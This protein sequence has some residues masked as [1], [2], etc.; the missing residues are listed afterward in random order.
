MPF[1]KEVF[2][3]SST[4]TATVSTKKWMLIHPQQVVIGV[5]LLLFWVGIS[6]TLEEF[7]YD[8]VIHIFGFST[9]TLAML[10][11][12]SFLIQALGVGL[13]AGGRRIGYVVTFAVGVYEVVASAIRHLYEILAVWPYREGVIS[14]VLAAGEIVV[15]ALLVAAS[16]WALVRL[17]RKRTSQHAG[18]APLPEGS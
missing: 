4:K 12:V 5:A 3:N 10:V 18:R 16:L 11:G 13:V 8:A 1:A 15:G 17:A 9:T 6:H 2:S 14:K 7:A